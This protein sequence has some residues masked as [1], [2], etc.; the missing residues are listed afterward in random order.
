MS[1]K[2]RE[3]LRREFMGGR[4]GA[5]IGGGGAGVSSVLWGWPNLRLGSGANAGCDGREMISL[6]D[7]QP[8]PGFC[9]A[10]REAF[11]TKGILAKSRDFEFRPQQQEL[12][13]AVAE[14][15]GEIRSRWSRRRAPAW[16]NRWPT[17]CP[18]R[19]SRWKPAARG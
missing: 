19:A 4:C 2:R 8:V 17:C 11:S 9:D 5:E 3:W 13:V 15:L 16:G 18:P 1:R 6:T 12:A 14:A 10:V 7:G